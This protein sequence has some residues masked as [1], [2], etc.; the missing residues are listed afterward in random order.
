ME[1]IAR[2]HIVDRDIIRVLSDFSTPSRDGDVPE[3]LAKI[4][5][6]SDLNRALN[7]MIRPKSAEQPSGDD[8]AHVTPNELS[9]YVKSNPTPYQSEVRVIEQIARCGREEISTTDTKEQIAIRKRIINLREGLMRQ[10]AVSRVL[11]GG[12]QIAMEQYWLLREN[13]QNLS[14]KE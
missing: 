12:R 3:L 6:D 14:K 13:A 2:G 10:R 8:D 5:Q 1:S 4:Q 11:Y 7:D 9:Q